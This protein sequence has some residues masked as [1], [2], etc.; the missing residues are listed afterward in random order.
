MQPYR[1]TPSTPTKPIPFTQHALLNTPQTPAPLSQPTPLRKQPSQTTSTQP[2]K[3]WWTP[4]EDER[5]EQ[6]VEEYGARNWKKIA[7]FLPER[8]DV[9]CLHRWQKV[10]NPALVK[11]PWVLC[12]PL[13]P[14]SK[15]NS[16]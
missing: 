15:T 8:T 14:K 6:L 2:Q 13:R 3:H 12:P 9:Q 5:L 4:E 11:G 10:L 1:P 7:S 16:C